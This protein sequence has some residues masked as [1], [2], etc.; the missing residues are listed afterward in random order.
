M[1]CKSLQRHK[2]KSFLEPL[3]DGNPNIALCVN[4]VDFLH[5]VHMQMINFRLLLRFAYK[6]GNEI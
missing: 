5:F 4:R 3:C 1:G 6:V 2:E